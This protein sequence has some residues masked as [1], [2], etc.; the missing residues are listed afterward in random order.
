MT[1]G[2]QTDLA[3]A[4][5]SLSR[6]LDRRSHGRY[7][8]EQVVAAWRSIAGRSVSEHT[9]RAHIRGG[10]LV[11]HVDSPVWATELSALAGPYTEAMNEA[12]GRS[13]V[14]SI[15]FAVSRRVETD[16]SW[17]AEDR[18][19]TEGVNAER[20]ILVPLSEHE[21]AQVIDS[22]SSIRDEELREAVIRATIA[23]MEWQKGREH[24]KTREA[25]PE[26]L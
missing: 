19:I 7:L 18:R 22:A 16:R 5:Q 10:E 13:V 8:Q 11:V 17:D 15:R 6:R 14:K 2:K 21:K 1:R 23:G 25:A 20:V 26:G 4:L 24:A 3:S 9:T 12:L